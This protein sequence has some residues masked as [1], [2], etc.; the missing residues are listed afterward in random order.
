MGMPTG[1]Q[2]ASRPA[3]PFQPAHGAEFRIEEVKTIEAKTKG[4]VAKIVVLSVALG[5][6]ASGIFYLATGNN[7]ALVAV[8]SV[9]GPFIGAIV[10]HYFGA[11]RKDTG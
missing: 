1:K 9:G 2:K 6:A 5:I 8:W 10:S 7:T 11:R 4:F 3:K